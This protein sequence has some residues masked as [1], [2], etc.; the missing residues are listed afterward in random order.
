MKDKIITIF[1]TARCKESL[2]L[3]ESIALYA[4]IDKESIQEIVIKESPAIATFFRI[5]DSPTVLLFEDGEEIVR[6]ENCKNNVMF[7]VIVDFFDKN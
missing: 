2:K 3:L 5:V 7:K 4:Q 6:L 1:R